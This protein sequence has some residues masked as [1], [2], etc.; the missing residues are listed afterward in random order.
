M[1]SPDRPIVTVF[2]PVFNRAGVLRTT[3]ESVFAQSFQDFEL[4]V[5]DDGST[6]ASVEVARGFDDP[7]LRLVVH[8]GN[9]GIPATRNHGLRLARGE[10]LAVVDSDD[11]SER[12]RLATQVAFLDAQ[13]AIAAVG[14]WALRMD[15]SGRLQG[16]LLRP[17]E[18]REIR[19]RILFASCFKSPTIMARTDVLRAFGYREQFVL[20][21]DVDIWARISRKHDLANLPRFLVRYRAGGT[22]HQSNAPR[23][24]MRL[25]VAQDMLRELGVDFTSSDLSAHV[26]LRNLSGFAPDS[27]YLQWCEDWFSRL[28]AV[29]ARERS[30]PEPEFTRAAAKRG[31]L[32]QWRA[33]A[34]R[35]PEASLGA[36]ARRLRLLAGGVTGY[37]RLGL[38][39]LEGLVRTRL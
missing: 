28:L 16:P 27:A 32:V 25:L 33:R 29:N 8:D 21:S 11:V 12:E 34:A 3:L 37:S 4:L 1:S 36:V 30:Y 20:A 9:Q 35:V 15:A 14:S 5:V 2:V 10:Y 38:G 19:G 24:E 18:S 17:I 39:L 13:P 7:R 31:L 26:Q 22:S 23:R 6:D